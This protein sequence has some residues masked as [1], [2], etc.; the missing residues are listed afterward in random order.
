MNILINTAL[1]AFN[2]VNLTKS[3]IVTCLQSLA[4]LLVCIS[5]LRR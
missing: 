2:S 1:I 4:I 3:E 5:L